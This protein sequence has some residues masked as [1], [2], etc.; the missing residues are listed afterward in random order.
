MAVGLERASCP[1]VMRT[2]SSIFF[3]CG[4]SIVAACSSSTTGSQSVSPNLVEAGTTAPKG[5]EPCAAI[6]PGADV[7]A[8]TFGAPD[9]TERHLRVFAQ[10]AADAAAASGT[11]LDDV[12]NACKGIAEGLDAPAS[13]R[14]DA[15]TASGREATKK[16]CDLAASALRQSAPQLTTVIEPETCELS[17]ALHAACQGQCSGTEPCDVQA[18]PVRCVGGSLTISCAG[19]CSAV[20]G[21][22]L[23]CDGKC[24]GVCN[25]ACTSSSGVPCIGR[26][27]GTCMP[28]SMG[29]G[30]AADGTCR[31]TC[32]GTC[33]QIAPGFSCPG[34]CD[35]RCDAS[36][37]GV[38]GGSA[39]CDG[40]CKGDYE[41]LT[42]SGT[43]LEGGCTTEPSCAT[44][45][46]AR[47]VSKAQCPAPW[48]SIS[49][50]GSTSDPARLKSVL[51]AHLPALLVAKTRGGPLTEAVTALASLSGTYS[52][53]STVGANGKACV[54]RAVSIVASS[55]LDASTA[56]KGTIQ[57]LAM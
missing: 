53:N 7:S 47:V 54:Q 3:V 6:H 36:C 56:L 20:G 28:S 41:P 50:R 13:A 33:S 29:P 17:V 49:V 1:R 52:T 10:A 19:E 23:T 27:T 45:C 18:H 5:S 11:L 40:Q 37:F 30:V 38:T 26:C 22:P 15:E 35:G 32:V 44:S 21:E 16:W 24:A 31:G 43:A 51:E 57:V 34:T 39:R 12:R 42:C 46:T 25:G 55:A 8:L 9:P 14:A 4:T 2:Y 48:I